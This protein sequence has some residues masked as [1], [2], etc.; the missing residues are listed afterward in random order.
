MYIREGP[1]YV[2]ILGDFGIARGIPGPGIAVTVVGSRGFMAPEVEEGRP[3]SQ[4]ADM[5]GL[6]KCMGFIHDG[7]P[8]SELW[9]NLCA[10]LT[11]LE[12]DQRPTANEVYCSILRHLEQGGNYTHHGHSIRPQTHQPRVTAAPLGLGMH[13]DIT[14][15]P[16]GM[17]T[18]LTPS[19]FGMHPH[20]P[21]PF[22]VESI[23]TP[24][25][26]GLPPSILFAP[27]SNAPVISSP[28][29]Q[30]ITIGDPRSAMFSPSN[31][32][33]SF[34]TPTGSMNPTVAT[35]GWIWP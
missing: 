27:Y 28:P 35:G 11:K 16:F 3:C 29:L 4:K 12:P 22:C 33:A 13:P 26:G 19:L 1:I 24:R 9:Q 34:Q 14:P 21:P 30:P 31:I 5:F 18:N 6:G 8:A 25:L 10:D 15:M 32:T 23:H 20:P 7:T 17:Q 2:F